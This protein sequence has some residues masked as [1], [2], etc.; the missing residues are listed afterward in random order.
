MPKTKNKTEGEIVIN[1]N[2]FAIPI[3]I[4]VAGLLIAV[5]IF[6][7]NKGKDTQQNIQGTETTT[8]TEDKFTATSTTVDDDPYL[9]D[10]DKVKVA[11]V[12]FSDFQC[13]YC[14]RHSDEV[15]PLIKSEYIDTGKIVYVFRD[16]QFF[17]GLSIDAAMGGQCLYDLTGKDN[18]KYAEYHKGIF[19]LTSKDAITTLAKTLGVD[20][21]KFKACMDATKYSEEISKDQ[22]D[23]TA[24]GVTGTPGFVVGVLKAD[25]TVEGKFVGG[26]YPIESFRTLIDEMLAK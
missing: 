19:G 23:G 9:G 18:S 15:F 14:K 22:T 8:A 11:V 17:G 6:F 24:A 7:A 16:Y 12:E 13:S 2:T 1:L 20:E 5:G 21:S 25:G 10:K 4:I 26:A 3:A